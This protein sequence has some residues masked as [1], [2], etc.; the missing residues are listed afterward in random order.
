M[1]FGAMLG[2][3]FDYTTFFKSAPFLCGF[4]SGEKFV[5]LVAEGFTSIGEQSFDSCNRG[6]ALIA[7]AQNVSQKSGRRFE[8]SARFLKKSG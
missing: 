8:I 3:L 5:F 7:S 2:Y 1:Q 4:S 6:V